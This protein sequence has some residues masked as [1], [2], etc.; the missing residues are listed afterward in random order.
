MSSWLSNGKYVLHTGQLCS[1]GS[2]LHYSKSS[3][4]WICT[5]Q[6]QEFIY[7]RQSVGWFLVSF[8][9]LS[10][11][12]DSFFFVV[13]SHILHPI[14]SFP[15]LNSSQCPTSVFPRPTPLS[16]PFRKKKKK[17]WSDSKMSI[18]CVNKIVS[19]NKNIHPQQNYKVQKKIKIQ[20][21]L[22]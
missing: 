16:F 4:Q 6:F 3:S 8:Y 22:M 17:S 1:S 9:A 5:T 13:F 14:H 19:I 18:S 11:Y 15:S 20:I 10:T 2:S 12:I 21:S 7:R